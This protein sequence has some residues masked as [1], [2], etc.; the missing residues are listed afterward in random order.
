MASYKIFDL[1][2]SN[3]ITCII[4]S[5]WD[6]TAGPTAKCMW[7]HPLTSKPD[8]VKVKQLTRLAL[9]TEVTRDTF[10]PNIDC[11][12]YCLVERSICAV[13]YLFGA[14]CK[15]KPATTIYCLTCVY[16]LE[17][18]PA[19]LRW[20]NILDNVVKQ[21]ISEYK[22]LLHQGNMVKSNSF[23]G[24]MVVK[25]VELF[26]RLE[27]AKLNLQALKVENTYFNDGKNSNDLLW[28]GINSMLLTCGRAIVVGS[29]EE[30]RGKVDK[31]VRSL[32]LIVPR[33]YRDRCFV[34]GQLNQPVIPNA[35]V[36][37][38]LSSEDLLSNPS[39]LLTLYTTFDY[40]VTIVDVSKSKVFKTSSYTFHVKHQSLI[41]ERQLLELLYRPLQSSLPGLL[42]DSSAD[43]SLSTDISPA[44]SSLRKQLHS[45]EPNGRIGYIDQYLS[46]LH[47]KATAIIE[48]L[49]PIMQEGS[50]KLPKSHL[51]KYQFIHKDDAD[52]MLALAEFLLPG[53]S[54]AVTDHFID[55]PDRD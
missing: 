35:L 45:M 21:A 22:V 16:K 30:V 33:V 28:K 43:V 12:M 27:K 50:D 55:K 15:L 53:I 26:H 48:Y 52:V 39:F 29:N 10:C 14:T 8:P 44:I 3:A 13:N 9:K 20:S 2:A 41:R 11:N 36:Q 18:R 4:F 32:S 38:V 23:L 31:C 19:Y 51:I 49:S 1:P 24:E 37:G 40:P 25:V 7:I 46:Y 34:C 17:Q 5:C 42:N 47:S 6:N 54:L